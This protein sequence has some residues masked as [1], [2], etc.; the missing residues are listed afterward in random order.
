[1]WIQLTSESL[2]NALTSPEHSALNNA[3]VAQGQET[4]LT[5]IASSVAKEW[6]GGL[7]RVCTVDLRDGYVPDELLVHILADFRYRAFT[8]LPGMKGLLDDL[9]IEEWKR[10]NQVRDNLIKVHIVPPADAYAESTDESGSASPSVSDPE[11]DSVL[12]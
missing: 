1:M 11:E 12:L 6:R 5:D 3:A 2:L 8:R 7:R 9:R 4:V 10:A